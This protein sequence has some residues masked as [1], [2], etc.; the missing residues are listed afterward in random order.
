MREFEN[1]RKQLKLQQN[2]QPMIGEELYPERQRNRLQLF[3]QSLKDYA[4]ITA[5]MIEHQHK[6]INTLPNQIK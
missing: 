5:V 1:M 6:S 2:V 4:K 3:L